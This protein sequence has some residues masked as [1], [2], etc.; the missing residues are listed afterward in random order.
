LGCAVAPPLHREEARQGAVLLAFAGGHLDAN[1]W[2]IHGILAHA[3]SA[4]VVFLWGR[5]P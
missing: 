3:Q 1:S 4:N 5:A 2:I